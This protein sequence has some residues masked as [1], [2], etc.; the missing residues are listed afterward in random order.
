LSHFW[1]TLKK[2]C[3]VL[4]AHTC[5]SSYS[6]GRDQED[7]G[8]KPA[9]AKSSWDPILKKKITKNKRVGEWFKV[10]V[11]SSNTSTE[12]KMP[13]CRFHSGTFM[14]TFMTEL[15]RRGHRCWHFKNSR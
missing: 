7:C 14:R 9:R 15:P 12:K 13:T 3:Q 2:T 1:G 8:S 6:G 11:L 5:N 10:E 4:V